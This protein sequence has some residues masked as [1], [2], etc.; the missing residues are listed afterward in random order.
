[1]SI[2]ISHIFKSPVNAIANSWQ[3]F[4]HKSFNNDNRQ[5]TQNTVLIDWS[6]WRKGEK[7]M[8]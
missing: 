6:V 1:M 8:K 5:E 7:E 4:I 3:K 2:R